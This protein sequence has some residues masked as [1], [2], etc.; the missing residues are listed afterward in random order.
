MIATM[1]L[2][3]AVAMTVHI[4]GI[5][6][7]FAAFAMQAR[8]RGRLRVASTVEEARPWAQLL[9]MTRPMLPSGA[10]MLLGSGGWLAGLAHLGFPAWLGVSAAAVL[11]IG[12]AGVIAGRRLAAAIG[13]R[14]AWMALS[15]ANGAALGIIWLM[16][17][18][19]PTAASVA[20]VALAALIGAVAARGPRVQLSG[21]G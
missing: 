2:G 19:P 15:A 10:A 18:R 7:T 3:F 4:L 21:S 1:P 16:A 20:V 6:A 5:I 8:A 17:A 11:F 14:S 12:L 9:G 13:D